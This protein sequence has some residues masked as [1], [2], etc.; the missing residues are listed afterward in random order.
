MSPS[1]K[2]TTLTV[3]AKV[4]L[5]LYVR[6][7]L[8]DGYHRLFSLMQTIGLFDRLDLR[9]RPG[10]RG[11]AFSSSG[12]PIP[13]GPDNLVV[14][15]A[16]RFL[17]KYRIRRGV[18]IHLEKRIPVSAGLGGGSSDAA[19]TLRGLCRLFGIRPEPDDL[20]GIAR[21]L[22][23]DVP[24]FLSGSTGLVEGTGERV[25]AARLSGAGWLVVVNTGVKV[26]TAWAYRELDRL[27]LRDRRKNPGQFKKLWLTSIKK[28]N[29]ISA[30]FESTFQLKKLSPYLHN[31]LEE[32]TQRSCPVIG[33][34]K[35]RLR[36]L[37]AAGVLMSGSGPTVFGLFFNPQQARQAARTLKRE[38]PDWGV[39]AVKVLSRESS[40]IRRS[41]NR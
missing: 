13:S 34:V 1:P 25:R 31:D 15:A 4:N 30:D 7:T 12:L 3:P 6:E 9:V 38:R 28:Q 16:R 24:F 40:S 32:A 23:S 36:R 35:E 20:T 37:G 27:R 8:P 33:V 19:G 22:G 21:S 14:R 26:S 10:R 5:F 11:V 29:K 39:W 18:A 41:S 17:R 2:R